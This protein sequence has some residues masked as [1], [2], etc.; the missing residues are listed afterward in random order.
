MNNHL[1][2]Q[3]TTQ[4]VFWS[5]VSDFHSTFQGICTTVKGSIIMH[6]YNFI[7]FG[8]FYYCDQN[9]FTPFGNFAGYN[10]V[11]HLTKMSHQCSNV[12]SYYYEKQPFISKFNLTPYSL[13]TQMNIG[14]AALQM[15]LRFLLR[16]KATL[17]MFLPFLP[18]TKTP[19]MFEEYHLYILDKKIYDTCFYK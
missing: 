18:L 2:N 13:I 16:T 6:F 4:T 5:E 3:D 11:H 9:I 1:L 14:K 17:Q 12:F 15:F 10:I 8:L 7:S 19:L